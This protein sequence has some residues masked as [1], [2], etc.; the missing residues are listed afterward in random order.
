MATAIKLVVVERT[1]VVHINV[2][3]LS[4]G[5]IVIALIYHNMA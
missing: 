5:F 4:F 2:L 1:S 3:N